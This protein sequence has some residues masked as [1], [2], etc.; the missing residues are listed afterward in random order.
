MTDPDLRTRLAELARELQSQE[1]EDAT[2]DRIVELA[3]ELVPGC[4]YA[5]ISLVGKGRRISTVAA[6]DD[7]ARAGDARQYEVDQGPCLDSIRQ[8]MTV[9]SARLAA[10]QRWPEWSH[11][12]QERLGVNSMLCVQLF[13]SADS[14]GGLSLYSSRTDAFDDNDHDIAVALAAHAAVALATSREIENLQIALRSRTVIGQ[15]E[16]ILMERYGI[17]GEQAFRILIRISQHE[18][19]KLGRIAD[20]VVASRTLP[21]KAPLSC[22]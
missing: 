1:S 14:F 11:W 7:V 9:T 20:E 4:D 12:V 17:T 16:G 6:T 19:R 10:E 18:N 8:E 3:V 21:G 13:T 22:G 5:G 15:A 2:T